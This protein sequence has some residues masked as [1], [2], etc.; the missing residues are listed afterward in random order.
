MF[1][2]VNNRQVI[3]GE[4]KISEIPEM[5]IRDSLKPLL[6]QIGQGV[7]NRGMFDSGA[8]EVLSL[9]HI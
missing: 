3:F 5:C 7:V 6:L 9:I 2:I 1:E 4:N 8:D